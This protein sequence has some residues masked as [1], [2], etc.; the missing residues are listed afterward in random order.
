LDLHDQDLQ[1]KIFDL[2]YSVE[3]WKHGVKFKR[4]HCT[5]QISTDNMTSGILWCDLAIGCVRVIW[6]RT[7]Y[8][9]WPQGIPMCVRSC[10]APQIC[11]ICSIS[12]SIINSLLVVCLSKLLRW[13]YLPILVLSVCLQ[14]D[15][16][17]VGWGTVLFSFTRVLSMVTIIDTS[18][19]G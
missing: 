13:T 9:C 6:W 11:I 19:H 7:V 18:P 5:C 3:I 2:Y 17:Y 12:K 15:E 10:Q 4:S 8:G 1:N 14:N 16:C